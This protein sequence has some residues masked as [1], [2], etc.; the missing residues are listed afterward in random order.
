MESLRIDSQGGGHC[1]GGSYSPLPSLHGLVLI[2]S[3][4]RNFRK[5][6]K[7]GGTETQP[8]LCFF[9]LFFV[10]FCFVFVFFFLVE[11]PGTRMEPMP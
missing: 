6:T 10:L 3:A 11:V 4:P 1:N 9:V 2:T 8:K 7:V 5:I